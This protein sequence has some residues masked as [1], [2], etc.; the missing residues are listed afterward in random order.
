M[1]MQ[2]HND[3]DVNHALEAL[4]ALLEF[5]QEFM[6]R[7]TT[8]LVVPHF[9]EEPIVLWVSTAPKVIWSDGKPQEI[10]S[11]AMEEHGLPITI[12]HAVDKKHSDPMIDRA[13]EQVN[14][15][16]VSRER[17]TTRETTFIVAPHTPG[18]KFYISVNGLSLPEDFDG[19]IVSILE[20]A[21]KERSRN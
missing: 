18:E 21:L 4:L 6:Q 14:G 8:V 19:D 7:S 3:K 13:I 16:N 17:D 5:W 9:S 12:A 20:S 2:F 15:E 10:L 1:V 11:A